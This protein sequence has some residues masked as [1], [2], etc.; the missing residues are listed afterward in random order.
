MGKGH[1]TKETRKTKIKEERQW[2]PTEVLTTPATKIG[3]V[4]NVS[5]Y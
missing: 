1:K 5:S 4:T 3:K 2:E